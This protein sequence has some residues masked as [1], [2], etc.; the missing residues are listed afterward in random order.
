M[1]LDTLLDELTG[2]AGE[3][4]QLQAGYRP[5]LLGERTRLLDEFPVVGETWLDA[6]LSDLLDDTRLDLLA[7]GRPVEGTYLDGNGSTY[8]YRAQMLPMGPAI[9]F[10]RV[11]EPAEPTEGAEAGE[12]GDGAQRHPARVRL[13]S[14]VRRA[15]TRGAS[16]I[17]LSQDEVPVARV[18]EGFEPIG[19]RPF[20]ADGLIEA[21]GEAFTQRHHEILEAEGS[22]DLAWVLP[23]RGARRAV[24]FRVNVFRQLRGLAVALRPI[25]D[26]VPSFERLNLPDEI[27]SLAAFPHGMV[28]VTG[29]T[30][31][32][33]STTLAALI[34]H[35]NRTRAAHIITLEDPIEYV[36]TRKRAIVHQREVGQH[37]ASFAAG[38]R[39]ALRE[40]PDVILVGEMRDRETI[41]AALTAAETGHLVL[42]TLHAGSA[43]Q[44]IDRM[45]DIF[46][47]AQQLQVRVQLADVL[48]AVVTQRLLPTPDGRHRVPAV[49]IVRINYAIS[50]LI[51]ER[52]THLLTSQVQR[53]LG[54]GQRPF[55]H[56]LADLVRK[57]L[58]SRED[59][60]RAARDPAVV[61][62]LL[63]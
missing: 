27:A 23:T 16:D 47:E 63:G 17:L 54:E 25:W 8:Q 57:G 31:S 29:P 43:V 62:K 50:N 55:D 20:D 14:I 11:A 45:I 7:Q 38:L 39:A 10:R 34:E 35:L 40:N 30:G 26:R 28:L 49:E 24:R 1:E 33:K 48:R 32:G 59:A 61:E 52:K 51:R 60:L 12:P 6:L 53:G 42:S 18:A 3:A 46:P 44:A 15:L 22:V 13:E 58:V 5:A 9:A 41:A 21:L 4:L 56:S 36:Y 19:Q 2:A 37:V